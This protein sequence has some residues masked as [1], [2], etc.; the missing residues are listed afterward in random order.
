MR[1]SNINGDN[2][3]DRRSTVDQIYREHGAGAYRFALRLCGE[4]NDAEDVLMEAFVRLYESVDSIR[5][6]GGVKVW[7]YRAVLNQWR[8]KIRRKR[9]EVSMSPEVV[10]TF[11]LE[12]TERLALW[13]AMAAL[14]EKL[15][16]SVWL[17]KGE[18]MTYKEAAEVLRVPMGTVQDRVFRGTK[19]L[20]EALDPVYEAEGKFHAK[21]SEAKI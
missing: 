13:E 11:G 6:L 3:G 16:V 20:R 17:V 19:K 10:D 14:P 18:G 21:K 1:H 9:P 15:R 2:D 8:K 7:L 5:D 4:Q 12:A